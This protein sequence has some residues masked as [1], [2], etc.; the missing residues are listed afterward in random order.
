MAAFRANL[1]AW[2]EEFQKL[3]YTPYTK[4]VKRWNSAD[5]AHREFWET[6]GKG[7]TAGVWK[8]KMTLLERQQLFSELV[9]GNPWYE[10]KV[11]AYYGGTEMQKVGKSVYR[12][13]KA[14]DPLN[15]IASRRLGVNVAHW[16]ASGSK[17]MSSSNR[18]S[19]VKLES[20]EKGWIIGDR[21]RSEHTV[22]MTLRSL[23]H[24]VYAEDLDWSLEQTFLDATPAG[25]REIMEML[26]DVDWEEFWKNYYPQDDWYESDLTYPSDVF[27]S[28]ADRIEALATGRRR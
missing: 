2:G 4:S 16:Y 10:A 12:K 20:G 1:K 8:G 14:A 6:I 22:Q 23:D 25:R 17:V 7:T 5:E 18:A 28:I 13:H 9:R 21:F 27:Y 19:A 11:L 24:T 26:E 3:K 15:A